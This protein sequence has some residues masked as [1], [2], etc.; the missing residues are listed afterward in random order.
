MLPAAVWIA[1]ASAQEAAEAAGLDSLPVPNTRVELALPEGFEIAAEFARAEHTFADTRIEIRE[2]PVALAEVLGWLASDR[3]AARGMMRVEFGELRLFDRTATL[4]EVR[5]DREPHE[6]MHWIAVLGDERQSLRVE[7][8]TRLAYVSRMREDVMRVL[9]SIRWE[10]DRALDLQRG[11][12]FR[13]DA[14]A[15]L[16]AAPSAERELLLLARDQLG[17]LRP[18]DPRATVMRYALPSAV[19]DL[20][21]HAVEH[22]RQS[23]ELA[24]MEVI[25]VRP[26]P[27]GGLEGVEILADASAFESLAPLFAYQLLVLGGEYGYALRGFAPRDARER[28][29]A[30][31]REL[32]R[33][34]RRA[35]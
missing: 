26:A 27:M 7:A 32:A 5:E 4:A 8:T 30:R 6:L 33:T 2:A 17:P 25:S 22:L 9:E 3:L 28:W 21:A 16:I 1:G 23:E 18:D 20:E 11:R 29:L 12:P 35:R 34:F 24:A 31:F 13:V 15:H 10:P 14:T 19:D